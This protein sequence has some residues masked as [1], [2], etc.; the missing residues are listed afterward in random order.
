MGRA[1]IG[2]AAEIVARRKE[3]GTNRSQ[4]TEDE[5]RR[6]GPQRRGSVDFFSASLKGEPAS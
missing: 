1:E 2:K 3:R 5:V 6:S 4:R